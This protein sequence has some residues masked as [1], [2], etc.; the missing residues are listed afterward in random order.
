MNRGYI[1]VASI[2]LCAVLLI[3]GQHNAKAAETPFDDIAIPDSVM[4]SIDAARTGKPLWMPKFK[5]ISYTVK[6]IPSNQ[7]DNEVTKEIEALPNGL[8]RTREIYGSTINIQN[9][10]FGD[11]VNL[12][13]RLDGLP[14]SWDFVANKLD[15]ELPA[16]LMPGAKIASKW[17]ME[18]R[19]QQD[20]DLSLT[21][22]HQCIVKE[23]VDANTLFPKL[24]GK[25]AKLDCQI[26][27]KSA[28]KP[29]RIQK[30][31]VMYLEDLGLF[32]TQEGLLASGSVSFVITRMDIE[33]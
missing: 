3:A 14:D 32:F 25:A 33:R 22:Y 30:T 5:K 6:A 20:D 1:H 12:K 27:Y 23:R 10:M 8:L 26:S 24:T 13:S 21:T 29:D 2:A 18:F 19:P 28:K 17:E 31:T 4:A 11:L 7:K 9:I 15:L 16:E